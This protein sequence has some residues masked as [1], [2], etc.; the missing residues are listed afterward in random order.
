M[1]NEQVRESGVF[2]FGKEILITSQS[3]LVNFVGIKLCPNFDEKNVDCLFKFSI[4]IPNTLGC[5]ELTSAGELREFGGLIDWTGWFYPFFFFFF[6]FAGGFIPQSSLS[7]THHCHPSYVKLGVKPLILPSPQWKKTFTFITIYLKEQ[8]I[9]KTGETHW[10]IPNQF[11]FLYVHIWFL[12]SAL[13][14]WCEHIIHQP[15]IL[16][17]GLG[18]QVKLIHSMF[19]YLK[20]HIIE[21]QVYSRLNC[22]FK[23]WGYKLFAVNVLG[24]FSCMKC[25]WYDHLK[26]LLVIMQDVWSHFTKWS[27]CKYGIYHFVCM[28]FWLNKY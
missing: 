26:M 17:V 11:P 19:G 3:I 21:Y 4:S 1:L 25:E 20:P 18:P 28:S 12:I 24:R 16:I 22:A 8:G 27:P 6:E 13:E 23:T 15:K 5:P 10:S 7:N 2:K 14:N 9:E